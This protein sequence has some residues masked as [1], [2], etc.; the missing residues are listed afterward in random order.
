MNPH[1]LIRYLRLSHVLPQ[2]VILEQVLP[3][4]TH[5]TVLA[6]V[7]G[8]DTALMVVMPLHVTLRREL[9]PALGALELAYR[10]KGCRVLR[11]P[12]T[13]SSRRSRCD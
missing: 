6:A 4:E 9:G 10:P 13:R 1:S 7:L 12:G 11:D 5:R 8:L 3:L 2:Y